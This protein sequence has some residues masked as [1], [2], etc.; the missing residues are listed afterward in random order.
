MNHRD[1]ERGLQ[2]HTAVSAYRYLRSICRWN[3]I[4]APSYI[5]TYNA[6]TA[7]LPQSSWGIIDL[8][9]IIYVMRIDVLTPA[10]YS[11]CTIEQDLAAYICLHFPF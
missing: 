8:I 3:Y 11:I 9:L 6:C 4:R 7:E 5:S 2:S 1:M 10:L